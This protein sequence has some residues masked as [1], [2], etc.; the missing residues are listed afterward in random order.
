MI[1][2]QIK[3]HC[4]FPGAKLA[5][6]TCNSQFIIKEKIPEEKLFKF[7]QKCFTSFASHLHVRAHVHYQEAH[8]VS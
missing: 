2:N 7:L 6:K 8:N 3:K 5:I 1:L 4:W